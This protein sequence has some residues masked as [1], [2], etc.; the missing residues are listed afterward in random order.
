[1]F[2]SLAEILSVENLSLAVSQNRQRISDMATDE[3]SFVN[4]EPSNAANRFD[5]MTLTVLNDSTAEKT[6]PIAATTTTAAAAVDPEP[7]FSLWKIY[8][9][10]FVISI[11][12][13][14]MFTAYN[15]MATLQ[16]SLNVEGNV[17]VNSLLI[18]YAFLLVR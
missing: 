12:F 14:L 6:D 1:M 2:Y 18:T 13:I 8:K 17:G 9:N 7:I 11:A 10:L 16:S 3:L 15:G 4:D 5:L